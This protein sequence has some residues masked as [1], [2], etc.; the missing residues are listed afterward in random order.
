MN[1]DRRV[2]GLKAR[3]RAVGR[4]GVERTDLVQVVV[5]EVVGVEG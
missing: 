4:K 1:S 3:V 2:V 5:A